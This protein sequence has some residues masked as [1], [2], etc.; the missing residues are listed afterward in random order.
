MRTTA[1]LI[2]QIPQ[3]LIVYSVYDFFVKTARRQD[4]YLSNDRVVPSTSP[5]TIQ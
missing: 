5:R 3:L 2:L 1:P 4:D